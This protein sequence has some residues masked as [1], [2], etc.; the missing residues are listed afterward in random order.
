MKGDWNDVCVPAI[1]VSGKSVVAIDFVV[2]ATSKIREW[3]VATDK[4]TTYYVGYH[5]DLSKV[6]FVKRIGTTDTT[7][8]SVPVPAVAV[9]GQHHCRIEYD[10]AAGTA[11]AYLDG[12]AIGTAENI[13]ASTTIHP[14]FGLYSSTATSLDASLDN[15]LIEVK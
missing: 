8:L 10:V 14:V 6:V 7:L 2:N 11:T 3:Q 9:I 4:P 12:A 5:Q 1:D 15:V 13:L